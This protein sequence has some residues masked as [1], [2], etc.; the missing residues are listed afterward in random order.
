MFS[1]KETPL[2]HESLASVLSSLDKATLENDIPVR[3]S[4]KAKKSNMFSPIAKL[5]A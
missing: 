2:R 5:F 3:A 1:Q 4:M